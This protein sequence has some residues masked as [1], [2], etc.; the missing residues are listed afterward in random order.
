MAV[1]KR[2]TSKQRKRKRRSH[3][4]LATPPTSVCDRCGAEKMPHTVCES[5]GHYRGRDVLALDA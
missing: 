3:L 1:P 2:K 5:C 4:A